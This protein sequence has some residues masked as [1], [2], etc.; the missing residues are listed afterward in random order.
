MHAE[1]L[2]PQRGV[3]I[4]IREG[5][6]ATLVWDNPGWR[7]WPSSGTDAE[8]FSTIAEAIEHVRSLNPS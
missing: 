7:L 6:V 2:G 1:R 5:I 3:E 4:T 8:V